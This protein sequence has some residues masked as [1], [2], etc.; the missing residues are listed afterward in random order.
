M[1]KKSFIKYFPSKHLI[2][3]PAQFPTQRMRDSFATQFVW[4]YEELNPMTI[5]ARLDYLDELRSSGGGGGGRRLM[6]PRFARESAAA[7]GQILQ[8]WRN[9]LCFYL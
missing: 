5:A 2:Y 9:V 8:V 3:H 1:L 7:R 4:E 6:L